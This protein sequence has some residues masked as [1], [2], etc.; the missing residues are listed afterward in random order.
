MSGDS[1]GVKPA[2][3]LSPHAAA[4]RLGL[5]DTL[6]R[7]PPFP[8]NLLATNTDVRDGAFRSAAGLVRCK[9]LR[10]RRRRLHLATPRRTSCC[11]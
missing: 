3:Q 11:G 1:T 8:T 5:R 10:I 6:V 9:V 2:V 4:L 7:P